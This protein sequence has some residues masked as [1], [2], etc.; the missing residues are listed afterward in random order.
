MNEKEKAVL[1]KI[2]RI[3]HL[4]D[5]LQLDPDY[6]NPKISETAA[7]IYTPEEEEQI[8]ARL[9]AVGIFKMNPA[10]SK[11]R[12]LNEYYPGSVRVKYVYQHGMMVPVRR[13]L[14]KK[15]LEKDRRRIL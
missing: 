6:P 1:D 2:R 13:E 3:E 8:K 10:S 7:V 11:Q 4:K 14:H 5:E 12:S 9:R 15:V